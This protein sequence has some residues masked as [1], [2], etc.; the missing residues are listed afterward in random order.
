MKR[1]CSYLVV[2]VSFVCVRR[3]QR[4]RTSW[5]RLNPILNRWIPVPRV[6]HPYP[7]DRFDATH[8]RWEP[9]A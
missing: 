2:G 1:I 6:L 8:P 4:S 7:S 9:Y 3:S 5:D